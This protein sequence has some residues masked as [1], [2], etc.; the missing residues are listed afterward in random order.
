MTWQVD[1]VSPDELSR[2]APR[3]RPVFVKM[4]IEGSEYAVVPEA[5][6]LWSHPDLV[7]LLSTHP[8]LFGRFR[9]LGAMLKTRRVLRALS[10]YDMATVARRLLLFTR[11]S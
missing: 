5:K 7:L 6:G 2:L 9:Q 3:D 1:V 11:R 4:D 10:D 8:H